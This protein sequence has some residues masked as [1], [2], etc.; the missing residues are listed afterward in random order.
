M[1]RV[2]E[3]G[4]WKSVAERHAAAAPAPF[5][6]ADGTS[7]NLSAPCTV[8]GGR[9]GAGK[10]RLL[11]RIANESG[12]KTLFIDLHY[13]A[14][15]ALV[16][17]REDADY[18]GLSEEAGPSGPSED[19]LNDVQRVLKREYE[20]IEWFVLE[21]NPKDERAAERFRW[22]GKE[23]D[24]SLIPYFKATYRG[25]EYTS[26]D[27]GL[28]EFSMHFL[29]WILEYHR[30][31]VGLVVLLDE[32]D[33]FLPPVGVEAL[34]PRLL[35]MCSERDWRLVLST[36]SEEMIAMA[37]EN[38]AFTLLSVNGAGETAA[39]HV[40]DDPTVVANVLSRPPVDAVLFCEDEVAVAMTR[41]LLDAVDPMLS[42]RV[43]PLWGGQGHGYLRQLRK[44]MPRPPV[45]RVRFAYIFDGDQREDVDANTADRWSAVFLPTHDD[46][47]TL[48]KQL[49]STPDDLADRLGFPRDRV[50]RSIEALEGGDPHDWVDDLGAEYGRPLVLA[51]IASVWARRNLEK[52]KQFVADLE[53]TWV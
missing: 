20:A 19:R 51:V 40:T 49:A 30:D 22:S 46:P 18:E 5:Q 13:L 29:F 23:G 27:M 44:H 11:R 32:P 38:N 8:I 52:A 31:E 25:C 17:L 36:H 6:L 37:A 2:K 34:L 7:I 21:L 15:Q 33:A 12:E 28:G 47:N 53:A 1:R 26:S 9:N 10:S 14:E 45:P 35:H 3:K 42:R 41:A 48:L 24:P 39:A 16:V 50:R 43:S 4:I